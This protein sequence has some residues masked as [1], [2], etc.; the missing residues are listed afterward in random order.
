[1][2]NQLPTPVAEQ[3]DDIPIHPS[4]IMWVI[5]PKRIDD[6]E[7]GT[8]YVLK[9]GW[10]AGMSEQE[11]SALDDDCPTGKDSVR[12]CHDDLLELIEE[13]KDLAQSPSVPRREFDLP[14]ELEAELPL[15]SVPSPASQPA[16]QAV[17]MREKLTKDDPAGLYR[18]QTVK[19]GKDAFGEW[20]G[21]MLWMLA[22]K[23]KVNVWEDYT[24]FQ[25]PLVVSFEKDAPQAV[26]KSTTRPACPDAQPCAPTGGAGGHFEQE[27][28]AVA[29]TVGKDV[30]P[31]EP[32]LWFDND[33][34]PWL[35]YE[36]DELRARAV[37]TE[38]S[39]RN[40]PD[41]IVRFQLLNKGPWSKAVPASSTVALREQLSDVQREAAELR[42][43][44]ADKALEV[45]KLQAERKALSKVI[46]MGDAYDRI[47]KSLG[48]EVGPMGLMGWIND[49]KAKLATA[50]TQLAEARLE[51]E[52]PCPLIH[53]C[54]GACGCAIVDAT[55]YCNCEDNRPH[56]VAALERDLRSKYLL[57]I[58][59]LRKCETSQIPTIEELESELATAQSTT[60]QNLKG[61]K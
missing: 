46:G 48:D 22:A 34:V 43:E 7:N 44:C 14:Q 52:K 58:A 45:I 54:C 5:K 18:C 59:R 6:P 26:A 9:W 40:G 20:D 55:G 42:N 10:T 8:Y 32:G 30:L 53:T 37:G 27:T 11:V 19:G 1:M 50:E 36:S 17:V 39:G 4:D 41:N 21:E 38:R 28:P 56:P 12:I 25:G 57:E 61:E 60:T 24:N 51:L 31:N 49:T 13:L 23:G 33:G 35:V 47:R 16:P 15:S 29:V 3:T 2:T